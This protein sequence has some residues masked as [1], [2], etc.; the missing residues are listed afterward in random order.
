VQKDLLSSFL[1]LVKG[2]ATFGTSLEFE[3]FKGLQV[4][5]KENIFLAFPT[6]DYCYLVL[7]V[8]MI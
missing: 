7:W 8:C 6:G 3:G 2:I 1:P 5:G 4:V